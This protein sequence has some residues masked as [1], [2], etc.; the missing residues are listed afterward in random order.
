[1]EKKICDKQIENTGISKQY[2]SVEELSAD[3]YPRLKWL[4]TVSSNSEI[5]DG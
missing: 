2:S 3:S 5:P 1:M 4:I